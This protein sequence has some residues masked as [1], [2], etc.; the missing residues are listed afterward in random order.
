M[1][2]FG[3][4]NREFEDSFLY[5]NISSNSFWPYRCCQSPI[6]LLQVFVFTSLNSWNGDMA[7]V[8]HKVDNHMCLPSLV[9]RQLPFSSLSKVVFLKIFKPLK[10]F[11][12]DQARS[13]RSRFITLVQAA[14]K[15]WTNF[16]CA[17]ALP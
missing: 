10:T 11:C 9:R 2:D 14:T 1:G 4:K 3:I 17:S 13:K 8:G 15:S 6:S 16:F 5:L 12:Y 7:Q